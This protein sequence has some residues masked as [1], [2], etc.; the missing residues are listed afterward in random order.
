MSAKVKAGN[1]GWTGLKSQKSMTASNNGTK[2]ISNKRAERVRGNGLKRKVGKGVWIG[3]V[4]GTA[5]W[6]AEIV[7]GHL[8]DEGKMA[9]GLWAEICACDREK[10][11]RQTD[12]SCFSDRKENYSAAFVLLSRVQTTCS[13]PS[14][15][16]NVKNCEK[17]LDGKYWSSAALNL[18]EHKDIQVIFIF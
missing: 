17:E 12:T 8:V 3:G 16:K 11:W 6:K 4:G 18:S 2:W 13:S 9:T 15:E 1:A 14:W 7:R 5:V 10:E